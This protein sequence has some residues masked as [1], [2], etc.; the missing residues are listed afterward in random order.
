MSIE[1]R[2]KEEGSYLEYDH[3][4]PGIIPEE[5][6]TFTGGD[7]HINYIEGQEEKGL[8]KE[9]LDEEMSEL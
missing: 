7:M 1:E 5:P 3:P 8:D 6:V 2:E 9:R 4:E